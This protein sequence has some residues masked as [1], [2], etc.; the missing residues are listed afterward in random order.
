MRRLSFNFFCQWAQCLEIYFLAISMC[1][2]YIACFMEMVRILHYLEKYSTCIWFSSFS[3]NTGLSVASFT[4]L[5]LRSYSSSTYLHLQEGRR[6]STL[7]SQEAASFSEASYQVP[8][9]QVRE[10]AL[11]FPGLLSTWL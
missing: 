4:C 11:L 5:L 10:S 7:H 9:K 2:F 6:N 3:R 1:T 8:C